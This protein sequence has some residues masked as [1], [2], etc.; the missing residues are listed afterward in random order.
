MS[1]CM[2]VLDMIKV[3]NIKRI[4]LNMNN[5]NP[6]VL[7]KSLF[8]INTVSYPF[9]SSP[10]A[11][12]SLSSAAALES[13]CFP[14]QRYLIILEGHH[15]VLTRPHVSVHL[16]QQFENAVRSHTAAARLPSFICLSVINSLLHLLHILYRLTTLPQ[17][18]FSVRRLWFRRC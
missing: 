15:I 1:Y 10:L 7:A 4:L 12:V 17:G 14:Q 13:A 2:K 5:A 9:L 16:K 3:S 6:E 11:F 18:A 8:L